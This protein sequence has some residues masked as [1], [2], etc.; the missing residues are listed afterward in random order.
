MDR[1]RCRAPGQMDWPRCRAAE[2]M[3]WPRCRAVG[4]C[5]RYFKLIGQMKVIDWVSEELK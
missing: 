4:K 3:G 2:Q 5:E 1:A